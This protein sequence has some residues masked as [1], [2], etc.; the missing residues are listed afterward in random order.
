MT[1]HFD[2]RCDFCRR[3]DTVVIKDIVGVHGGKEIKGVGGESYH[4]QCGDLN[5]IIKLEKNEGELRR[6][7][8]CHQC[9]QS[10]ACKAEYIST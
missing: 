9:L 4:Y 8:I 3:N 5:I 10:A 1:F 7:I 6:R 2:G